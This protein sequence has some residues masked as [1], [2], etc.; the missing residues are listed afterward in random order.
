MHIFLFV[1]LWN[2]NLS[3]S[4]QRAHQCHYEQLGDLRGVATVDGKDYQLS[5][6]VMRDHT[7]GS[8]R[9]WRLMHRYGIQNFATKTG[10]RLVI[11]TLYVVMKVEN[12]LVLWFES[13]F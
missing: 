4:F 2:N 9:D 10:F 13:Y 6:N 8:T 7:H 11:C 5:L 12:Y 1:C 3:F